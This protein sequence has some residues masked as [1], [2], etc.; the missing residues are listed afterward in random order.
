M[1]SKMGAKLP[2]EEQAKVKDYRL[3]SLARVNYDRVPARRRSKVLI[4]YI[5]GLANKN[6]VPSVNTR[7]TKSKTPEENK[8]RFSIRF[9]PLALKY[10]QQLPEGIPVTSI[11]IDF[12][13][14]KLPLLLKDAVDSDGQFKF[15]SLLLNGTGED[16]VEY[17][18]SQD[19]LTCCV[20]ETQ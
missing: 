15:N 8:T 18:I 14:N 2:I 20:K 3:T 5:E 4:K 7:Y 17:L 13:E 9:S 12:L 1:Y 19:A 11:L 16:I 10:L 6:L